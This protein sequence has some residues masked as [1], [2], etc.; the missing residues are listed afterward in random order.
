MN[1][2]LNDVMSKVDKLETN[3]REI[4]AECERIKSDNEKLSS[5][6]TSLQGEVWDQQQYSR[7]NNK[8]VEGVQYKQNENVHSILDTLANTL[9]IHYTRQDVS[10]APTIVEI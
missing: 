6:V 10:V 2:K 3:I 4:K 8:E 7:T 1:N 9:Q 5:K